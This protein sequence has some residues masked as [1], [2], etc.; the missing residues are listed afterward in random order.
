MDTWQ[1]PLGLPPEPRGP[2]V[3]CVPRSI[4]D[5]DDDSLW[6]G[7]RGVSTPSVSTHSTYTPY[8]PPPKPHEVKIDPIDVEIQRSIVEY[9]VHCDMT[10]EELL[11]DPTITKTKTMILAGNGLWCLVKNAA[12]DLLHVYAPI[13]FQAHNTNLE[14]AWRLH[15]PKLPG[16]LVS[17]IL[18]F[19]R[20]Y[21][22]R[23]KM[24]KVTEA[25]AQVYWDNNTREY[26]IN[27]PHQ[28][29]S[30]AAV[31]FKF[32]LNEPR[33]FQEGVFKVFDIHS[34]NTM[35]A[36]F[37]NIDDRDERDSDQFFGVIGTITESSH[38]WKWRFGVNGSFVDIPVEELVDMSSFTEEG[39]FPE[40]WME[41]VNFPKP[42]EFTSPVSTGY[43][44]GKYW[45]RNHED[46]NSGLYHDWYSHGDSGLDF[47]RT[48]YQTD[49]FY[50]KG[51]QPYGGSRS[52]WFKYFLSNIREVMTTPKQVTK[53]LAL[54][55]SGPMST[56][57]IMHRMKNIIGQAKAKNRIED[58]ES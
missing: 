12:F 19:F 55:A 37:S 25:M 20:H 3:P 33:C 58:L 17:Q 10:V 40:L 51:Q 5:D 4:A 22:L 15:I 28:E 21:T 39:T 42:E 57:D 48:G 43:N 23:E 35:G 18:A 38:S 44:P 16:S 9:R 41:K 1:M 13:S 30:G 8:V 2:V 34:H 14:P 7:P 47:A 6:E 11:D 45:E 36:F 53:L 54:A 52:E 50:P 31:H 32:D 27:V 49:R 46:R 29:V 26:F 24:N 56:S